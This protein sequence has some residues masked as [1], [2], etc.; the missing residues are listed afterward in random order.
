MSTGTPAKIHRI[1]G[2]S[3]LGVGILQFFLAGLGVFG[4]SYDPHRIGGNVVLLLALLMVVFAA[5]GRRETLKTSAVLVG[6]MILQA[7]LAI[8][9]SEDVAVLGA[10]HPVNGLLILFVAHQ[11]ARGLPLPIGGNRGGDRSVAV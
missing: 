2:F 1:L 10:L 7:V 6:L 11:A 3:A 8:V 4:E 5:I 9:G